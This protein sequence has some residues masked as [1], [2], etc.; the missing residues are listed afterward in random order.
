M[1]SISLIAI[2][3]I[4]ELKTIFTF[5]ILKQFDIAQ[6]NI[7]PLLCQNFVSKLPKTLT[8]YRFKKEN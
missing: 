5:E 2:C 3:T 8:K 1:L 6:K 7:F 4:L